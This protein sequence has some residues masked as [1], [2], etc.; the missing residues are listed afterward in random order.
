MLF[1]VQPFV[2]ILWPS[3]DFSRRRH[4]LLTQPP[5]VL[6][7]ALSMS[8]L[9]GIVRIHLMTSMILCNFSVMAYLHCWGLIIMVLLSR[10]FLMYIFTRY[11][12]VAKYGVTVSRVGNARTCCDLRRDV[13]H[14][15]SHCSS[16]RKHRVV[17]WQYPCGVIPTPPSCRSGRS[18]VGVGGNGGFRVIYDQI[19]M[20]G[21]SRMAARR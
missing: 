14:I 19:G 3:R 5:R 10:N 2:K 7:C 20:G 9:Q 1:P 6:R 4:Q 21:K 18:F 16:Q 13:W 11:N 12:S 15:A 8:N 17:G